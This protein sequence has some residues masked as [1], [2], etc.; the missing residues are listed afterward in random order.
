M[1]QAFRRA[2]TSVAALAILGCTG[3]NPA[4]PTLAVQKLLRVR[5]CQAPK[6]ARLS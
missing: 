3:D 4:E 1:W 5:L 6:G 2:S